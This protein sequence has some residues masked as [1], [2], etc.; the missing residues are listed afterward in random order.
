[1]QYP[2]GG[3]AKDTLNYKTQNTKNHAPHKHF[4]PHPHHT[5]V[6]TIPCYYRQAGNIRM[7][8]TSL[9]KGT[10]FHQCQQQKPVYHS[11][12]LQLL[13]EHK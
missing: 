13:K 1:M 9:Q 5:F 11:R 10:I 12:S 2:I 7:V 4:L 3:I 6:T 8:N